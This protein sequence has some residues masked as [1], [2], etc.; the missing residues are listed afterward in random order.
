MSYTGIAQTQKTQG[1]ELT[2]SGADAVTSR[3]RQKLTMQQQAGLRLLDIAQSEGPSLQPD[4][5]AFVLWQ[6]S[7]GQRKL[8]PEKSNA[9]LK[10]AFLTTLAVDKPVERCTTEAE[11]CGTKFWLQQR[12]LQEIIASSKETRSVTSLL[13]MAE[14]DVR[15]MV[16][17]DLFRRYIRDKKFEDARNLLNQMADEDGYFCYSCATTL[18]GALPQKSPERSQVFSQAVE[19]YSRHP[20]EKYPTSNDFAMMVLSSWQDILPSLV[21]GALDQILD[22]AKAADQQEGNTRVGI[23]SAKD[24]AYFSS[25]YQ[26]R[27]YQLMPVFEQLDQSRAASLLHDNKEVQSALDRY[28]RGMESM[29]ALPDANRE[30]G[31]RPQQRI[32]SIGTIDPMQDAAEATRLETARQESSILSEAEKDPKRALSATL[33][34]PAS[35][36]GGDYSPR[37]STLSSL[38]RIVATKDPDVSKAALGEIRRLASSMPA[39]NQARILADLPETYLRLGDRGLARETIEGLIKTAGKLYE[40]DSDMNDPNQAFKGMW[41]SANLWRQCVAVATKLDPMWAEEIVQNIPDPEIKS[42]ERI[43]LANSLLGASVPSLSII[44]KHKT[45]IRASLGL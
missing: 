27:L 3:N 5:R 37:S 14:P 11:L 39:R 9:L 4:M 42:F 22:R 33:A 28:P 1:R 44:E 25:V 10:D 8:D 7:Y 38:A 35:G 18:M 16:R 26:F 13:G 6:A 12:I 19:A 17:R 45:G 30:S 20:D 36:V 24:D 34:L 23:S 40:L 15:Q 43:T 41:P 31:S 2:T 32:L 29:N 21:L